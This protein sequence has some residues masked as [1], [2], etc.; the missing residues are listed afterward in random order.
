MI[1]KIACAK[2]DLLLV[3]MGVPL[4]DVWVRNNLHNL[5]VKV[6]MGVGGLFD[7]YSGRIPRAP[8][9][10]RRLGI[11]WV[12]R[13]RQE[14]FRMWRRYL[15]GNWEFLGHVFMER[16]LGP[17]KLKKADMSKNSYRGSL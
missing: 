10:M 11:E 5:N 8:L 15:I 14:P 1:E 12:Y 17:P 16:V 3:A 13:L 7:F 2:V 6:A 9:W 4:Q